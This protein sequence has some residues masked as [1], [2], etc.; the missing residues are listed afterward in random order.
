MVDHLTALV[1]DALETVRS[2]YYS[3]LLEKPAVRPRAS[4]KRA[5][6][7]CSH[8]PVIAEIKPESPSRGKLRR[9]VN[10]AEIAKLME[11]GGAVGISVLTEPKRFGG[12]LE[13]LVEVKKST[14]L[15]VLM[16]DIV[17]DPV[18]VEAASRLRADAVLLILSIFERG[19]LDHTIDEL[20]RLAHSLGLEVLLETHTLEEFQFALETNAD[21]IGINNRNIET[22]RV[23]LNT[24]K[25][26]LAEVDPGNHVVVSESG[27]EGP[28]DIRFLRRC[29]ARAF[30]VGSAIMLAD[31]IQ[32]KV[33]ELVNAI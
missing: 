5:V 2:G 17:V 7:E 4:F 24:T 18:Q 22:L 19:I 15:P 9:M 26:I 30:L 28:E 12:S 14:R 27:I 23:D 25:R 3:S 31:N 13:G 32:E 29:G 20:I 33:R 10:Y 21:L 6:L 11:A 16:K 1:R 8:A